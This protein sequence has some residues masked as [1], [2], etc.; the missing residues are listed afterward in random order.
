LILQLRRKASS[1]FLPNTKFLTAMQLP[2]DTLFISPKTSHLTREE[3]SPVSV[4]ASFIRPDPAKFSCSDGGDTVAGSIGC[5]GGRKVDDCFSLRLMWR[6]GGRG[7]IYA[8]VPPYTDPGFEANK[9]LCSVPP[10]SDCNPDYGNSVG[11]GAFTFA[12][13]KR[14]FVATRVLLNTP[15][16]ANG[17]IELFANGESVISVKGVIIRDTSKGRIRGIQMKSFFGYVQP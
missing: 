8:Y 7:E 3:S 14:Y 6:A 12:P 9:I 15:G 11:R 13:G 1:F 17:E 5:S 10:K 4:R 2:S 16:K